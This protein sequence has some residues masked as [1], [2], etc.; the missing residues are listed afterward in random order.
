M[1]S[2]RIPPF[3]D[4][5]TR[6]GSSAYYAHQSWTRLTMRPAPCCNGYEPADQLVNCSDHTGLAARD[7][8]CVLSGQ[9]SRF[10]YARNQ[11]AASTR[12]LRPL[13]ILRSNQIICGEF[14][15][16]FTF[17]HISMVWLSH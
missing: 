8:E 10:D 9:D 1:D 3:N 14:M 11:P 2:L 7:N 5:W 6:F 15:V 4:Q 12:L 13:P 16:S 17:T